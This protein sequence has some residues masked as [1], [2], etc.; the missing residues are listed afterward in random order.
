MTSFHL[1]SS[2]HGFFNRFLMSKIVLVTVFGSWKI[3]L[4]THL[5][6]CHPRSFWVVSPNLALCYL[7]GSH[8]ALSQVALKL[9]DLAS[10]CGYVAALKCDYLSRCDYANEYFK[11]LCFFFFFFRRLP[12]LSWIV[13]GEKEIKMLRLID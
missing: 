5:C 12:L 9:S 11:V 13:Q 4:C 6:H 1:V 8:V 7:K 2:D 10:N 3:G